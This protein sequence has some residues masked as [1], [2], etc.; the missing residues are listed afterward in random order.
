M[1]CDDYQIAF[2]QHQA[3]GHPAVSLA[4]V[5]AHVATCAACAA[6][7]SIS[8]KVSESMTT[9][10][11]QSPPA[12]D[13][14]AIAAQVSHLRRR[15]VRGVITFS[16]AMGAAVLAYNLAAHGVSLRSVIVRVV[17]AVVGTAACYGVL[18]LWQR[19]R[20]A[21]LAALERMSGEA[22]LTGWRA[23]LERQMRTERQAW[24]L[25]PLLVV[26]FQAT[27]V[28]WAWPSPLYLV[29]EIACLAIAL[30]ITIVRYRRLARERALLT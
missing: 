3:G 19:R 2:D 28:G 26:L 16:L 10:L 8:Q 9:T 12:L 30:P 15:M 27:N 18:A 13:L 23:E 21:R 14:G 24:W 29:F 17:G 7:V 11:A 20:I 1:T 25:M 5:T 4:E 6:Y 22:L